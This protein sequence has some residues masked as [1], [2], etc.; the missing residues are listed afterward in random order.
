MRKT[1]K[2][3][4]IDHIKRGNYKA[5][6]SI[7]KSFSREFKGSPL[8][9]IQIANETWTDQTRRR[10]YDQIGVNHTACRTR[11]LTYMKNYAK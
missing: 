11:A 7:M 5:A 10:Y 8:R 3:Q 1:K 9:D 4:V 2:E 6:L